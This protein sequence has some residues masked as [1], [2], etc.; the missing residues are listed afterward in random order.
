MR[1]TIMRRRTRIS[2]IQ[3]KGPSRELIRLK[4]E[5]TNQRV[6]WP[7][8][9]TG[10][11][12]KPLP[13]SGSRS[14]G[15]QPS[16][17]N[18]AATK[19]HTSLCSYCGKTFDRRAALSAH[20]K[21][22][23]SKSTPAATKPNSRSAETDSRMSSSALHENDETNSN[24]ADS[25]TAMLN[26]EKAIQAK[27]LEQ[28][29]LIA[30]TTKTEI[31]E[32]CA[33]DKATTRDFCG[34]NELNKNKRKRFKAKKK[35]I[36]EE[37]VDGVRVNEM[38]ESN[39]DSPEK[40]FEFL[41]EN[42]VKNQVKAKKPKLVFD[43]DQITTDCSM[44]DRKFANLSNLRRHVSMMHYREK[45][46]GCTLCPF[47]AFRKFDVLNHLVTMHS[48]T[49]DKQDWLGFVKLIAIDK[50]K[51]SVE[52]DKAIADALLIMQQKQPVEVESDVNEELMDESGPGG[53]EFLIPIMVDEDLDESAELHEI[54]PIDKYVVKDEFP[55]DKTFESQ[56]N[57]SNDSNSHVFDSS[58][59]DA[60][61]VEPLLVPQERQ[62]R[63]GRPKGSKGK[64]IRQSLTPA[65]TPAP[66]VSDPFD[67]PSKPSKLMRHSSSNSSSSEEQSFRRPVRNR[68][69]A[70][71]KDF[72]YDMSDLLK[73]DDLRSFVPI[74]NRT[75]KRK[76]LGQAVPSSPE[77]SF[78]TPSVLPFD[79]A[80]TVEVESLPI[81]HVKGAALAM[82]QQSV[83]GNR[84]C[85]NKQ[86]EP[87]AER[88]TVPA[89][90][91]ALRRSVGNDWHVLETSPTIPL[92]R[93]ASNEQ[94]L[95]TLTRKKQ[96]FDKLNGVSTDFVEPTV[97]S[98]NDHKDDQRSDLAS[99]PSP[100]AENFLDELLKS[101]NLNQAHP[102]LVN[103]LEM[104]VK[105]LSPNTNNNNN[106]NLAVSARQQRALHTDDLPRRKTLV[107]R[108]AEIKTKKMQEH[109]QKLNI[110]SGD[111]NL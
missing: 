6:T 58:L 64:Q 56:P 1:D 33:S 50:N 74:P 104:S 30:A 78:R 12:G 77:E 35:P 75:L 68:I 41:G 80:K 96:A 34:M 88:P 4:N 95:D 42:G 97:N 102:V 89:K 39:M 101:R 76:S 51:F 53:D 103:S 72:V 14:N 26:R 109:M 37:V 92:N 20:L 25:F 49:G 93:R 65:L 73:A 10:T 44:C 60:S 63:R 61:L 47:Q 36:D 71:N 45:K 54:I 19:Q 84:A 5:S 70:V 52:K 81:V 100:R 59:L 32:R 106:N 105:P 83:L 2:E 40:L 57:Q 31:G 23:P 29:L 91:I 7:D 99:L 13:D 108:L 48:M 111:E 27:I 94:L 107:E 55:L 46:F 87:P 28:E 82:A 18:A 24:S 11:G 9:Y 16:T 21:S 69:K 66:Y 85:F 43:E 98:P 3:V 38:W 79:S 62:K 22:C 8:N 17:K 15:T 67:P 86:S 110:S 90:I